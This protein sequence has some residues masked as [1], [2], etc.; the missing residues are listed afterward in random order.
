M[1]PTIA[2]GLLLSACTEAQLDAWLALI[3]RLDPQASLG[4][5][6]TAALLAAALPALA[7][8]ALVTALPGQAQTALSHI[9]LRAHRE[10]GRDVGIGEQAADTAE[11][12]PVLPVYREVALMLAMTSGSGSSSPAL[13]RS[14]AVIRMVPSASTSS[15]SMPSACLRR[16]PPT[17]A[18]THA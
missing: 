5:D 8:A 17:A 4:T 16:L 14:D 9:E 7:L 6:V 15:S 2:A 12:F 18:W 3:D 11:L 10:Q 13:R 1:L